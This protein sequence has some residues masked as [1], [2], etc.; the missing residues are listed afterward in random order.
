MPMAMDFY[1]AVLHAEV[2]ACGDADM[3]RL[4]L[5]PKTIIT[6]KRIFCSNSLNFRFRFNMVYFNANLIYNKEIGFT[7]GVKHKKHTHTGHAPIHER[8]H[9][10][11]HALISLINVHTNLP[12]AGF[13]LRSL[14][15]QAGVLPIEPPLLVINNKRS[16]LI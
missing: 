8:T 5:R 14:G 10:L 7:V 9:A 11:T 15:P 13:E 4:I 1:S 3:K 12:Q 2:F 6:T 16:N